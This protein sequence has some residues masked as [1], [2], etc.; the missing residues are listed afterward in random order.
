MKKSWLYFLIA[1][2]ILTVYILP[3]GGR[4]MLTLHKET[5][6]KRY[7]ELFRRSVQWYDHALRLDGGLFRDTSSDF[8][9]RSFGHAASGSA[10]AALCFLDLAGIENPSYWIS[11]AEKA[12]DF[13]CAMQFTHASDPNLQGAVLEKVLMPDGSDR[14]PYYLR[15]VGTI[16]FIQAAAAYLKHAAVTGMNDPNSK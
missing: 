14:L 1:A 7:L 2:I 6:D 9:T 15:D 5:G 3:L 10:C 4:P 12:L 13:C 16:F 11:R 8:N